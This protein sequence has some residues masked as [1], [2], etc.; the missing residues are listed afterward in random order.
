VVV[1]SGRVVVD[2]TVVEV[3]DELDVVVVEVV[4]VV[5]EVEVEVEVEVVV[6]VVEVEVEVVVLVLVVEDSELLVNASS[7]TMAQPVLLIFHASIRQVEPPCSYTQ[8][9]KI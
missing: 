4:V 2:D 8:P 5:V 1:S 9:S 7:G 3:E 6:V